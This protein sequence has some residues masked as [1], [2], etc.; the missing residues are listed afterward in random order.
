MTMEIGYR[1]G[2]IKNSTLLKTI[3]QRNI[4]R[5]PELRLT[6]DAKHYD[7]LR[8]YISYIK[9][10]IKD[11]GTTYGITAEDF[12]RLKLPYDYGNGK[13]Y[14]VALKNWGTLSKQLHTEFKGLG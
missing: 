12:D 4:L 11:T 3:S 9:I 6:I 5:F 8:R 13:G 2:H 10:I 14:R 7:N 1:V